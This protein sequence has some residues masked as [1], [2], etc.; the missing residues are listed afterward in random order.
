MDT[1]TYK[2]RNLGSDDDHE[3]KGMENLPVEISQNIFARLPVSSLVQSS[4]VSRTWSHLSYEVSLL[5][6]HLSRIGKKNP[7]LI[8]HSLNPARNQLQFVELASPLCE[9]ELIGKIKIPFHTTMPEKIHILNSCNGL[10]CISNEFCKDPYYIYNPFTKKYTKLSES[11]QFEKQIVEVGFGL[12]LIAN[13]Y[14]LVKMVY[15]DN[16]HTRGFPYYRHS[17]VQICNVINNT[18]RSIGR[19]PRHFKR[20]SMEH[21]SSPQDIFCLNGRLYWLM[22]SG[23]QNGVTDTDCIPRIVSFDL[24]SEQFYEVPKPA[25]G[26]LNRPNYLLL[27]RGG[28]LSAAVYINE[29]KVEIWVM[30]EYNVQE[31]WIKEFVIEAHPRNM[32]APSSNVHSFCVHGIWAN[33]VLHGKSVRVLCFLKNRDILIQYRD[34]KLA[35]YNLENEETTDLR[36]QGL[37]SKFNTVVH[38]GSLSWIHQQ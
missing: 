12:D 5:N 18:W 25:C 2:K 29:G 38:I 33:R 36:F 15:Y 32:N 31:S 26:G 10:L 7:S 14:K 28:C 17:E 8:F 11:R 9:N 24:S 4:N 22:G 16:S 13:E 23:E 35:S 20:P 3:R 30:K 37:P 19:I 21:F 6:L 27:V 1:I 34:G